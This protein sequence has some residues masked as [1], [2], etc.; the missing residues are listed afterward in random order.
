MP[1]IIA[2]RP[3]IQ[4]GSVQ[5]TD[6]FPNESQRNLVNDPKG[7]GPFYVRVPNIGSE[8]LYRPVIKV[9]ADN[10]LE[11]LREARG[12]LAYLIANVEADNGGAAEAL[13]IA[14]AQNIADALVARVRSGLKIERTDVN[15]ILTA[16]VGQATN[17]DGDDD[18]GNPA[19]NSTGSLSDILSILAG[20]DY[21]VQA[22]IDIQD[23]VG[24]FALVLNAGTIQNV[25]RSLVPNDTSWQISFSEGALSGLTTVRDAVAGDLFAGVRSTSPLL[26]VYNDDGTLY[27]G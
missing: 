4:N 7:Q 26:T 24:N 17:L 23:A 1:F 2:R 22:G 6:L 11:F 21:V 13:T 20:N 19:G 5:I 12:L 18:L 9:N 14:Q 8:G 15:A 25:V 27:A 16:E 3:E 10:S